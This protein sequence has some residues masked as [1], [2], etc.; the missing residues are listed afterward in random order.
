MIENL[1]N[2]GIEMIKT[3]VVE[4]KIGQRKKWLEELFLQLLCLNR[5]AFPL[6]FP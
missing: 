2:N 3:C 6:L 1:Q 5:K 4:L